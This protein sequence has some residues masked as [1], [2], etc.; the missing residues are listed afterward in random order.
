MRLGS[1]EILTALVVFG[2]VTNRIRPRPPADPAAFAPLRIEFEIG[3][4]GV[5]K[6]RA[7]A[8]LPCVVGRASDVEVPLADGEVSRRHA[9]FD[10]EGGV[11]Y[12]SDLRSS[13]GTFLNGERVTE[14]I[15]VRPGDILDVG[16][17]RMTILDR[18]QWK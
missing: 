15:E 7:G 5:G 10:A 12:L 1:L 9:K 14:S 4:P 6:R 17:T 2:V 18:D 11:V 16:S 13:N 8:P 3:E